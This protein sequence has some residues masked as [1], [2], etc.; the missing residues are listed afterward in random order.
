[1]L[2]SLELYF[3]IILIIKLISVGNGLFNRE[4]KQYLGTGSRGVLFDTISSL[5]H[6][7]I[8]AR[9]DLL[10]IQNPIRLNGRRPK[11]DDSGKRSF[12][13]ETRSAERKKRR[14]QIDSRYNCTVNLRWS[15]TLQI[16]F[17]VIS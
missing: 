5:I 7:T 15:Y 4:G 12:P 16:A 2:I 6:R 1:M 14:Q 8:V 10:L 11:G 17:F 3:R 13:Y 9:I